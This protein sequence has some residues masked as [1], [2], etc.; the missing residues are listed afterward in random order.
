MQPARTSV[1][2]LLPVLLLAAPTPAQPA[3]GDES[4]GRPSLRSAGTSLLRRTVAAGFAFLLLTGSPSPLFSQT[5]ADTAEVH[6]AALRY[7]FEWVGEHDGPEGVREYRFDATPRGTRQVPPKVAREVMEKLDLSPGDYRVICPEGVGKKFE[8]SCRLPD[9]ENGFISTEFLRLDGD[10]AA[11]STQIFYAGKPGGRPTFLG[12][13][14]E[15]VRSPAEGGWVVRKH[16][17]VE[18]GIS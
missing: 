13:T 18:R 4:E 10:T 6:V 5:G 17:E 3:D 2:A 7:T 11:V 8:E 14:L 16:L 9:G 1:A 12:L 15:L